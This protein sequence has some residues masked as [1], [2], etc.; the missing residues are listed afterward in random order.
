[1]LKV[2]NPFCKAFPLFKSSL[3]F[4]RGSHEKCKGEKERSERRQVQRKS[5]SKLRPKLR[6]KLRSKLLEAD[7]LPRYA[8]L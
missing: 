5:R 2:C 7:H 6:P 8:E 3:F 4:G 1:M